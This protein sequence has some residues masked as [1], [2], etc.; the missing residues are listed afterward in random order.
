M[1]SGPVNYEIPSPAHHSPKLG[2]VISFQICPWVDVIT[3]GVPCL[4]LQS[5]TPHEEVS[6]GS[7]SGREENLDGHGEASPDP[8]ILPCR[9]YCF[10]SWFHLIGP[11]LGHGLTCK[12]AWSAAR[13]PVELSGWPMPTHMRFQT[14]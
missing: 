4:C 3:R 14:S 8:R 10:A 12:S 7:K 2:K 5:L 6:N 11:L 1:S 13:L 9:G